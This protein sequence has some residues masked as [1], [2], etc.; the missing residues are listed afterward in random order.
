MTAQAYGDEWGPDHGDETDGYCG[1]CGKRLIDGWVYELCES[2]R[3][4]AMAG[5]GEW[6]DEGE[7]PA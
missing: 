3:A 1:E 2:C 4:E 7:L 5:Q 6:D